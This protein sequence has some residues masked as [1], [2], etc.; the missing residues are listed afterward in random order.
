MKKN[1]YAVYT[2]L[3]NERKVT[4]LL[5]KKKVENYCPQNRI[6]QPNNG[7]KRRLEFEPLFPSFVFIYIT[8]AEIKLLKKINFVIDFVYWLGNPVVITD[9]EIENIKLFIQQYGNIVIEKSK[10][11]SGGTT[12]IINDKNSNAA[13]VKTESVI[14][15]QLP[16]LGFTMVTQLEEIDSDAFVYKLEKIKLVV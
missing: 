1:W 3:N 14:K 15:L 13:F 5:S 11:N 6:T 16:S 4:T 8:E 12:R 10:V 7:S 2:K 9:T